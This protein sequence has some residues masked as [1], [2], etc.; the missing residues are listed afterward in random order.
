MA[1]AADQQLAHNLKD[2]VSR[3]NRG[4][5]KQVGNHG[6]LSIA[7]ENVLR[8]LLEQQEA[9]PSVLCTQLNISSQF[10]SQ[11]LNRLQKLGY[12]TRKPSTT[13]KRKMLV[14]LSKNVVQEI[15][16]RRKKKE[17]WLASLIASK[18]T[19]QQKQLIAE[20]I[21]LLAQINEDK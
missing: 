9:L 7:E 17:D 1:T 20:A 8:A 19:K 18:Y 3:L 14:L 4:F 13:D 11:V 21:T 5:R 10:M 16:Q 15:E 6:Q 2:L 12:I